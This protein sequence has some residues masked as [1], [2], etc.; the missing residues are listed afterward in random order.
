M[1]F[2]NKST[3]ELIKLW[4]D[5]KTAYY[6]TDKP[7]LKDS[8]FDELENYLIEIDAIDKHIG[9]TDVKGKKT[10]HISPMLSLGKVQVFTP[11]FELEHFEGIQKKL[12]RYTHDI[13]NVGSVLLKA[14]HK[15][16]GLAMNFM[17]YQ[18][19]LQTIATR[20]NGSI[21]TDVTE[22]LRHMV[23][24]KL[25]V[26]FSG[27]VRGEV[28]VKKT[29]FLEKYAEDYKN[30][31]N[32]ASGIINA[33]D[34]KDE[35]V[36]DLS[37]FVFEIKGN[38]AT[39]GEIPEFAPITISSVMFF[40]T[41]EETK[42]AYDSLQSL[43]SGL[44]FP[45]DGLVIRIATATEHIDDGHEP[46]YAIAVKFPPM[47]AQTRLLDIKW[48]IGK[49]GTYT[50]VGILEPTE[51]DGSIVT[52]VGLHNYGW[53]KERGAWPNALITIGKN[54]DI[55]PQIQSVVETAPES[56]LPANTTVSDNGKH[57]ISTEDISEIVKRIRFVDGILSLKLF[58][59]GKANADLLYDAFEGKAE[60]IF[61]NDFMTKEKLFPVFGHGTTGVKFIKER[62]ARLAKGISVAELLRMIQFENAGERHTNR[63]APFWESTITGNCVQVDLSGLNRSVVDAI[64]VNED[65]ARR[66]QEAIKL[67]TDNGFN[68]I[69][70]KIKVIKEGDI[71]F[72]MTGSPKDAGYKT[73]ED[74]V[75]FVST[76]IHTKLKKDTTYLITDDL[77]SKTSKMKTAEKNGTKI[78]S[79]EQATEL[80]KES[81]N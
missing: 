57:L 26:P 75:K 54:G 32:L 24:N 6:N 12:G 49:S 60:N 77:T 64:T 51:L 47:I 52:K 14:M 5:A 48:E 30:P 61:R 55:I 4:E 59:I 81:L 68:W 45:T 2:E 28:F 78:L 53:V 20:G 69:I 3:E 79:Y 66:I 44:P 39:L 18:G 9:T 21:G 56:G 16:D 29:T 71:T 58:G 10:P 37:L 72:E 25:S 11:Q 8:E 70:P 1:N 46:L 22:K 38:Y 50:P 27:E 41:F 42:H 33:S 7:I 63:L 67:Y 80:F 40:N 35:R 34:D 73:K 65:N 17:Y 31:R 15:L 19:V 13:K 23:P 43:R 74:F 76:W 36:Q 62:N